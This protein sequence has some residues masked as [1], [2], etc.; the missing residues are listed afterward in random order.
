LPLQY[1]G[2]PL[3]A[4]IVTRFTML[5][6]LGPAKFQTRF[7]PYF[8]PFA[9][10]GLLFTIILIFAEQAQRIL[11]NLGPTFRVFV[12]MILYFAIMWSLAF[13]LVWWMSRRHGLSKYGGYDMAVVQVSKAG[14]NDTVLLSAD[15]LLSLQSFTAASNNFELAIAVCI[16]VYGVNSD[17]ALAAT[18]GP[19]VEVPV[20]L[21]LTWLALFFKRR[22]DWDERDVMD[23]D[24]GKQV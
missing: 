23:G 3:I 8:S 22:L 20:L 19:L 9:L 11:D 4:G 7:L 18:I 21:A 6:L 24:T 12:P 13:Y 1:L 10:V 16:A 14:Y 17:Q 5:W 2:I 15:M